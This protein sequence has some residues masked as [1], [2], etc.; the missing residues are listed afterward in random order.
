MIHFKYGFFIVIQLPIH[1]INAHIKDPGSKTGLTPIKHNEG[2]QMPV[3]KS[4]SKYT[5]KATWADD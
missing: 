5:V 1:I 2:V 3:P 4:L